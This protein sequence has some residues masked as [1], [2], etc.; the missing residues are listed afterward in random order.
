MRSSA[1]K[2]SAQGKVSVGDV[3]SD[4]DGSNAGSGS[5][6]DTQEIVME[7]LGE[8]Q[9]TIQDQIELLTA[10]LFNDFVPKK[11]LDDAVRH[12]Q[13]KLADF[14]VRA[15]VVHT[16]LC[17]CVRTCLRAY[18]LCFKRTFARLCVGVYTTQD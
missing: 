18:A 2:G 16:C 12:V 3:V 1:G 10:G 4:P 15:C 14:E 6:V 7:V 9:S 5:V 17:V 11:A 8:L 13:R